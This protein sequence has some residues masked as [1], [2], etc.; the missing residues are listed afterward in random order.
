MT[1]INCTKTVMQKFW[2]D[3]DGNLLPVGDDL[4]HEEWA[5]QH[6]HELEALLD[7]G[8]VRVQAVIP[9]YC[10]LD[11]RKPLTPAQAET[12]RTLLKEQFRQIVVEFGGETKTFVDADEALA[13]LMG[14]Q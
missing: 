9:P 7:A 13:W 1:T 11:F 4:A 3:L 12:I 10:Y 2:I 8:W 14:R 5:H 6:G